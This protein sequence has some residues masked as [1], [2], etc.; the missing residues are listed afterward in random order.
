M[1]L[2]TGVISLSNLG[3]EIGTGNNPA[4][5]NLAWLS[6][7]SVYNFKDLNSVRG[8]AWFNA[9][10]SKNSVTRTPTSTTTNCTQN[11]SSQ[12]NNSRFDGVGG[13]T[14]CNATAAVNCNAGSYGHGTYI[15]GNC[16][17]NCN[18]YNCNCSYNNCNCNCDCNCGD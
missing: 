14:N 13:W 8:L 15:Q 4:Y 3:A 1:T 18:C 12:V 11:C 9:V 6:A 10:S 7:N 5:T 16:N 17:C 2:P